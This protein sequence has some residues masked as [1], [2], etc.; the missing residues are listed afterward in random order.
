MTTVVAHVLPLAHHTQHAVVQVDDLDRQ[1]VLQA[2]RQL[3]DVHLD[4][5][6]AGN[7]GDILVREAQLHA[8]GR[9]ETEAHGAQATGVDPA[10]RLVET[11]VLGREHLMLTDVRSNKGIA[12]G[13]FAQGLDHCLWLDDA[14]VP[15][16][17][18]EHAAIAAPLI[19][20]F[21]PGIQRSLLWLLT[22]F[23]EG[24]DHFGQD[25]FNWP[26]D[27]HVSLDGLGDRSRVD[28]DVDDLGI[29]AELGSTVDHAVVETSA[30]SEDH[31]GM[32][33]RQ[34]GGVT[35]V[36]AKH[37]EELAISTRI[38]TQAHQGIGNRHV[39]HLR[40]FGQRLRATA[41]DDAATGVND[42]ALGCQEHFR[43]F[44][45]LP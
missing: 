37:A 41:E 29:R 19:D 24:R 33:H 35:A 36:H 14:A 16:I 4:A 12:I 3:L 28:I 17:V 34:V 43:R 42:R 39:E 22:D 31:V 1:V 21:P 23:L 8:H 2:S 18:R 32:V 38:G 44:A 30:D 5:A 13:D 26:Y 20:L 45:D 40:N 27:R 11:V 10:V 15:L 7:A 9:R 6:F 25:A